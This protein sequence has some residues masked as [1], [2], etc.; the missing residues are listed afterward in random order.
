VLVETRRRAQNERSHG[1]NEFLERE[2]KKKAP[3][4]PEILS[5]SLFTE[6]IEN[7]ELAVSADGRNAGIIRRD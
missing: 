2:V 1:I 5:R 7:G 6:L 4:R 3:P